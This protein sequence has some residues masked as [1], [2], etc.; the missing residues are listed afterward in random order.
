MILKTFFQ[1]FHRFGLANSPH[2]KI[3]FFSHNLFYLKWIESALTG[4]STWAWRFILDSSNTVLVESYLLTGLLMICQR[5]EAWQLISIVVLLWRIRFKHKASY[6]QMNQDTSSTGFKR[7][8]FL[9]R[10][11]RKKW[12]QTAQMWNAVRM[13]WSK[14][15]PQRCGR[16]KR[17]LVELNELRR[18]S[19]SF[20]LV[21]TGAELETGPV[22]GVRALAAVTGGRGGP[23][24]GFLSQPR[25]PSLPQGEEGAH[26][27]VQGAGCLH[28]S[29]AVMDALVP[30]LL[31]H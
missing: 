4:E 3:L 23:G 21:E 24:S 16:L 2:L 29:D 11:K 31:Q 20:P 26:R 9:F 13:A 14:H 8:G 18:L 27:D 22:S 12:K 7:R 28:V 1:I 17:F 5:G 15:G 30:L 25:A 10:I 6:F 19:Q